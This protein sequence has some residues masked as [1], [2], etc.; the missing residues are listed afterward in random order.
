MIG[1]PVRICTIASQGSSR[2]FQ[3][4]ERKGARWYFRGRE[5]K[6]AVRCTLGAGDH[7]LTVAAPFLTAP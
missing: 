6:G 5:C 2:D 7:S 3:S 4:R 1:K